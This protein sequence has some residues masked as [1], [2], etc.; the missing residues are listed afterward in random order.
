MSHY[1]LEASAC[2]RFRKVCCQWKGFCISEDWWIALGKS[3]LRSCHFSRCYSNVWSGTSINPPGKPLQ[4]SKRICV[5]IFYIL[6]LNVFLCEDFSLG[7]L[8][9]HLPA[10][11][12]L[13]CYK[14]TQRL[15]FFQKW[16]Y[17]LFISFWVKWESELEPNPGALKNLSVPN[18]RGWRFH[19]K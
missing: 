5:F 1:W 10:T 4:L 11:S 8:L 15:T 18:L 7:L 16:W 6:P 2:T 14:D 3:F 9:T 17:D 12:R 19:E 13:K